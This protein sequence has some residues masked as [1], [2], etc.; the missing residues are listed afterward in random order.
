MNGADDLI[1]RFTAMRTSVLGYLR[2]LVRDAHL[3]ED[4]FQETCLVVLR[5]ID[6]FDPA[7]DLGAWVRGIALN[8]ARN[9]L[10]KERY[11][12]LM[13]SPNLAEA[14]ERTHAGSPSREDEELALRLKHL[15][16]CM[17]EVSPRHRRLLELRYR[18]G[19]SLRE[20]AR[21][22]GRTEGAVQV[23]LSRVRQ[24]LLR[25]L[26]RKTTHGYGTA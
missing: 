5:K 2:V 8:L 16:D 12:H 15:D 10:R 1:R 21:R 7:G 13:P 17:E 4:L 25:C 20:I 14:I 26:D 24:F 9:A 18:G 19:A 22:T 6:G 11:L 3:A 23:A